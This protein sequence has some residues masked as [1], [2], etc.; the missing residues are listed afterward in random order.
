MVSTPASHRNARAAEW[1][2]ARS[3]QLRL[4]LVLGSVLTIAAAALLGSPL[5]SVA[6]DPDLARL[7][8][9]MALV[10]AVIVVIALILLRWR[11]GQPLSSQLAGA[12]LAGAWLM[13]GAS[14]M[15]W[16]LAEIP[17]AAFSF[18][19]GAFVLLAAAWRDRAC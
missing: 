13:A 8:R 19:L 3:T 11:F 5:A 4:Y 14:M 10:K 6:A 9:G 16:Q 15:I 2:R 1:Q 7:L 12:Y 17:T 18:H